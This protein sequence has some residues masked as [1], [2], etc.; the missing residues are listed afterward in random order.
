M[1]TRWRAWYDDGSTYSA[2]T[3]A[4]SDLPLDGALIYMIWSSSRLRSIMQG[5]D[6]YFVVGDIWGQ[7]MPNDYPPGTPE[8]VEKGIKDRYPGA[9]V[10]RGRTVSSSVYATKQNAAYSS[11][12]P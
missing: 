6:Y 7:A 8:A 2:S 5:T 9:R 11:T 3:H 4:T 1:A 10:M 12:R